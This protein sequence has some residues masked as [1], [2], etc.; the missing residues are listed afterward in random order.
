MLDVTVEVYFTAAVTDALTIYC[1]LMEDGI[2]ANQSG[3]TATYVHNHVFRE[4]F[5]A[6]WGD[7]ISTPTTL[8][9]LKTFTFSFDNST[10]NYDMTAS[11]VLAFVRNAANEEVISGNGAVVGETS[12]SIDDKNSE[13]SISVYPNPFNENTSIKLSITNS[14]NVEYSIFNLAGQEIYHKNIGLLAAGTHN[15]MIDN[16]I[17]NTKGMYFVKVQLGNTN[18]VEKLIVE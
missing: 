5:V 14:E 16:I 15:I 10:A 13:N 2:V 17:A 4:A 1:E 12:V 6:Q 18:Y 9:T 11:E 7:P 3:G 8:G